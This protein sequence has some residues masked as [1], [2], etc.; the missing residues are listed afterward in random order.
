MAH[1]AQTTEPTGPVVLI[2]RL[3]GDDEMGE[4][5]S[6]RAAC[7]ALADRGVSHLSRAIYAVRY[8]D[9]SEYYPDALVDW[10]QNCDYQAAYDP[11]RA[12]WG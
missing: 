10:L 6:R 8:E 12:V 3:N 2:A 11:M 5:P 7:K 1:T 9:D 4:Y